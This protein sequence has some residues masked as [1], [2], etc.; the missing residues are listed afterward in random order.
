MFSDR[1]C[2]AFLLSAVLCS[3]SVKEERGACPCYVRLDFGE[4]DQSVLVASGC[5][6]VSWS[7]ASMSSA[8][9]SSGDFPADAL[10]SDVEVP[11][12]RDSLRAAVA[13]AVFFDPVNGISVQPG[14]SFP[15]LFLW[16]GRLDASG[17]EALA[18]PVLHKE[19]AVLHMYVKSVLQNGA[20]YTLTSDTCGCDGDGHPVHGDFRCPFMPDARGYGTAVLPRQGDT[21]LKLNVFHGGELVRAVVIGEYIVESGYDWA[22]EDLEDIVIEVDFLLTE[23]RVS[24]NQWQKS[25]SFTIVI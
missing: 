9:S 6:T 22:A 20:A 8:W 16:H 1:L 24:I 3:C 5:G 14:T 4:L 21:S 25:L 18:A 13:S 7:L 12:P 19:H 10:P 15:R 17:D 11:A 2:L 23:V